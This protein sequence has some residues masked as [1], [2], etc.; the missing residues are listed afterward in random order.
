MAISTIDAQPRLVQ[1][2][3]PGNRL[4]LSG[5]NGTY[6]YSTRSAL[7]DIIP[8]TAQLISVSRGNWSTSITGIPYFYGE[9]IGIVFPSTQ[10]SNDVNLTVVYKI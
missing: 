3:I 8:S 10:S 4:N 6:F 1:V 7:S 2:T 5:G 9:I